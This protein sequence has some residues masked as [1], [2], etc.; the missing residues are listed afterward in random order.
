MSLV[1][2]DALRAQLARRVAG[3]DRR[4]AAPGDHR[5]AAVVLA[6]VPEVAVPG[7]DGRP[8]VLL[9]R[10]AAGLRRHAGQWALPGGRIDPGETVVEAALRELHEE[11]ALERRAEHVL[12]A[13]DDFV[14][15]SGFIITPLVVWGGRAE[16]LRP[17]PEEVASIHRPTLEAIARPGALEERDLPWG[18]KPLP[19]LAI[20]DTL[21]FAPTAA[22]L[23]QFAQLALHHQTVRVA[24]YAQPRF[25]WS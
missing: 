16:N 18:D 22:I 11:V 25:A 9:T 13:L 5:R 21:I 23:H 17:E 15:R 24:H 7:E 12:G 6:I 14:T 8:A 19:T 20:L 3:F 10:R 1:F 2:D 4:A